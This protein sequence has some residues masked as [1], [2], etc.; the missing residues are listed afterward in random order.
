MK[1]GGKD[2]AKG[3]IVINEEL[4]KGCGLCVEF[5]SQGCIA[6]PAD[7]VSPKGSLLASFGNP[8]KCNGCGVC[9]W[10]CPDFAIA[11]YKYVETKK[12]SPA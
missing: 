5:C 8:D 10:M 1:I 2:M 9:G 6:M 4:C 7:K 11:V 12:P 3:E